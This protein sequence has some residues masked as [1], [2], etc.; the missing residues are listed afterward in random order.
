MEVIYE[1]L[2]Y[3]I[4]KNKKRN[5]DYIKEF[6]SWLKEKKLST[7]TIGKHLNNIDLYLNDYLNYY[8]F[9]K[10]EDGISYVYSF[11]DDWFIRKCA[12][13]SRSSVKETATSIKKFYQCMS[14]KGYV[15]VEDYK[16][17]CEEIKDNMDMFLDSVDAYDDDL[18]YDMFM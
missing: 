9:I 14:E 2:W 13:A 18:Y 7:K 12:W 10:M 4:K 5:D 16:S 8:E 15:K 1:R 3:R 17:L 6:E 11:L